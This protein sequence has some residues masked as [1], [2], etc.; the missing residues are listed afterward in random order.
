MK[1]FQWGWV[2][3]REL[4][5]WLWCAAILSPLEAG[6]RREISIPLAG[7]DDTWTATGTFNA[8]TAREFHTAVWTGR[9][10]IV[11]G[12]FKFDFGTFNTGGRYNPSDQ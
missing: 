1:G 11:W 3:R 12:G 10:M 7:A 2:G 5:V 4:I 8:P 9:E 6:N